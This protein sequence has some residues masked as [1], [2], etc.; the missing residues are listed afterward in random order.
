MFRSG[1]AAFL[2][3]IH[4]SYCRFC[5]FN[6]SNKQP[7]FNCCLSVLIL[8]F[9]HILQQCSSADGLLHFSRV[10]SLHMFAFL[11]EMGFSHDRSEMENRKPIIG[12]SRNYV[13]KNYPIITFFWAINA[14]SIINDFKTHGFLQFWP[15]LNIIHV[16]FRH[17]IFPHTSKFQTHFGSLYIW[18]QGLVSLVSMALL[19]IKRCCSPGARVQG[20]LTSFFRET[21]PR[22]QNVKH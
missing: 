5:I 12:L 6:L 21:P 20:R 13:A 9:I 22:N 14:K 11:S 16:Y 15:S 10:F 8:C 19:H 2:T 4:K 1:Q 17:L 7:R 18:I 3:F